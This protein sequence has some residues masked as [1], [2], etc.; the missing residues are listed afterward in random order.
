MRFTPKLRFFRRE[1]TARA[2]P[3]PADLG[4]CFGMEA[5]LEAYPEEY[6]SA[7]TTHALESRSARPVP[8][9]SPLA[10]LSR[11]SA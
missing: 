11:R 8:D 2:Q 7:T 9:A 5:S 4:T 10:W 6:R 3:D 1:S